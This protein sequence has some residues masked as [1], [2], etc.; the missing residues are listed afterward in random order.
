MRQETLC[1][2]HADTALKSPQLDAWKLFYG[3]I[4]HS[5]QDQIPKLMDIPYLKDNQ[6][7]PSKVKHLN[8]IQDLIDKC[9][10]IVFVEDF[11]Y[12]EWCYGD[13]NEYISA[14]MR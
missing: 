7:I 12:D 14:I 5:F 9:G 3:F 11:I 1:I 8:F 2:N 6:N 4:F 13:I 10:F